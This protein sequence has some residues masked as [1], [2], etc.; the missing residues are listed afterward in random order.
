MKKVTAITASMIAVSSAAMQC[1]GT[2]KYGGSRLQSGDCVQKIAGGLPAGYSVRATCITTEK[3]RA[4]M[5]ENVN[6]QGS[7]GASL[8]VSTSDCT[9]SDS[10]SVSKKPAT[11]D[12]PKSTPTAAPTEKPTEKPASKEE[13]KSP[14]SPSSQTG[15]LGGKEGES[16]E[17]STPTIMDK[18][19]QFLADGSGIGSI[20]ILMFLLFL[21]CLMNRS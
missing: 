1:T 19:E 2:V 16:D 7:P 8:D 11:K 6:C 4:D 12:E 14:E 9:C 5:F 3:F 21:C 10:E 15:G 17:A 20:A 18:V 13:S